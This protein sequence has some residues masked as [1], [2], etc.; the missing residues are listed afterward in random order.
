VPGGSACTVQR[1]DERCRRGLPVWARWW[2]SAR[3]RR[4]PGP[5]QPAAPDD[6]ARRPHARRRRSVGGRRRA[7]RWR[8]LAYGVTRH[9]GTSCQ[10]FDMLT[11][12]VKHLRHR[13]QQASAARDVA[14]TPEAVQPRLPSWPITPHTPDLAADLISRPNT[15]KWAAQRAGYHR[16]AYLASFPFVQPSFP[17]NLVYPTFT[18]IW[19]TTR[20]PFYVGDHFWSN[21]IDGRYPHSSCLRR[22]TP[23]DPR[24]RRGRI[25]LAAANP[26][27][28]R[29]LRRRVLAVSLGDYCAAPTTCFRRVQF[30]TP[31]SFVAEPFFLRGSH[32][33]RLHRPPC[34]MF[35]TRVLR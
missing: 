21:D 30:R 32:N 31:V 7:G 1:G 6:L 8:L 26:L 5:F 19:V 33:R 25:G 34:K 35:W 11:G 23:P 24:L 29:P 20:S 18:S 22:R 10:P 17:P 15:T 4:N 13:C 12:P 28:R 3:R 14:S 9:D 2:W 16:S 27:G